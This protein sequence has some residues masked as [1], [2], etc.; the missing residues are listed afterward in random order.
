[1]QDLT[2]KYR[3]KTFD[4]IVGQ[5]KV[6]KYY[7]ALLNSPEKRIKNA[8]FT[9]RCGVGKTTTARVIKKQF[10]V[11]MME[12]N[13]SDERTLSYFRKEVLPKM[14]LLPLKGNFRL[15]FIDETESLMKDTWM[16]LKTPSEKYEYNCPIIFACNDASNIPEAIYSRCD[17]FN[18]SPLSKSDIK[19]RCKYI[20]EQEKVDIP[21]EV[22]DSI[23]ERAR[24]DLR[25]AIKLLE[26]NIKNAM[27]F[28]KS[29]FEDLF[30]MTG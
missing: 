6:V 26:G 14:K 12:I 9:G 30:V 3:P 18:F 22:F 28:G 23:S 29:E 25:K 21:D 16:A 10:G 11:D 15:I 7:K 20:A 4:D 19:N 24:G 17:D 5:P 8:I 13:G 1:M 2:E 27:D